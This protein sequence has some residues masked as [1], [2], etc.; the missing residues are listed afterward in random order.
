MAG[1]QDITFLPTQQPEI[2]NEYQKYQYFQYH[3]IDLMEN[4]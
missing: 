4:S 2:G 3:G 1:T